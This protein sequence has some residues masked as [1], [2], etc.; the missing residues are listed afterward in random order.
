M[1]K[2]YA[3]SEIEFIEVVAPDILTASTGHD[4]PQDPIEMPVV[5]IG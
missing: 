2:R 1:K 4:D 5:P 3:E